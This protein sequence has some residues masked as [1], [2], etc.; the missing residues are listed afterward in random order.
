MKYLTADF[1]STYTKLAAIDAAAGAVLATATA[2]TTIETDIMHGFNN[3]LAAL[4]QKTGGFKYDELICC[5]SAGGGLKMVALGL[6]PEL[7]SKAA[8]MAAA[9]AGAKVVK[10]YAY[11]ISA[12]E[13]REIYD[14]NPDLVLLC[15]GTD[16]GNKETVI[17]NARLLKEIKR[18]FA[19]I[20]AGNK[21][22]AQS[23]DDIL[24]D[25]GKDYIITKNVMPVFN[26][27]DIEPAQKTIR[28][29]FIKNI[30]A[31]KGLAGVQAMSKYEIIPTP[32][33]VM[34][35]C[36]LLSIGTKNEAGIGD[37]IAVDLG[38]AT[39]DVYS[40]SKGA[41]TLD[42]VIPKGLP[43][44]YAKRTVEGDLGMR[45]SLP[46]LA[47]QVDI[48]C[49]SA[50]IN[51]A[52]QDIKNWVIQC[53]ARPDTVSTPGSKERAIDEAFARAAVELAVKR[54]CGI[55]EKVYTPLGE[56]FTLNGKDL[57]KIKYMIGIGGIIINSAQAAHILDGCKHTPANQT[58]MLPHNPA[59]M[60]D[61][62]YIF[63]AMGMLSAI[64]K[65]L[66]FKIL[67]EEIR[68]L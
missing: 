14:I 31:A 29:L 30:I 53:S 19:I 62:K 68:R 56:A 67:K 37:F 51:V 15:G 58:Y 24:K 4:N 32:L 22:A 8:K 3:A 27:I 26:Q 47:E 36:E 39:T 7:T 43:E 28:E 65:N 23:I 57:S 61:D 21:S 20:Y 54:H 18:N 64:D 40:M 9:N 49:M 5:S 41:P 63:S 60:R 52:P 55:L 66:A 33:A 34:R 25:S 46:T 16:G 1:G 10:T 35:G 50:Q 45:Y 38:G 59:Y 48:D 17:N 2:F 44:P 6:V 11:E 13:Q 42:N 12:H